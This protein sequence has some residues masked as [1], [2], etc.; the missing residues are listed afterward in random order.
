MNAWYDIVGLDDRSA[1]SCEGI[2]ASV[3]RI[4]D[5]L[6][7]ENACG[8]PYHRMLLTGFSQ[9]GFL[10]SKSF[11]LWHSSYYS[12]GG[13][14]SLYTGLQLPDSSQ[15]LAGIVVMSGLLMSL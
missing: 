11:N 13:A 4:R 2:N 10:K 3:V 7:A 15:K 6:A 9:V 1:E 12:K 5:I 8:L 14:L